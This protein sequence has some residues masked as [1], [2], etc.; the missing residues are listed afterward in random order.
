[1][2]QVGTEATLLNILEKCTQIEGYVD[3]IANGY[4]V[5]DWGGLK[6][7]VNN[8]TAEHEYPVGSQVLDTWAKNADTSYQ[9][10]WDVVDY[11]DEK[12]MYLKWHYGLPDNIQFDAPEAIYYA[13]S[14]GLAA[15]TY[16]IDIGSAYGDGWSTSK[17]IQ[18]TLQN[19]L[20]AGG[21]IYINCGTNYANDPT[22][23][24]TGY[25]YSSG[26]STTA[27]ETF[28]TSNGT[29]GT[30]LGTIGNE[31]TQ[32]PNGN[33]NA[34]SRVVYGSGRWSQSAIRQ[35]LNSTADAGAWW[36]AQNGWDRPPAQHTTLRGFL[37]GCP[38]DFVNILEEVEVV[39]ALNTVEGYTEASEITH[40]KIFLPSL[41][42][43]YINP[44][45]A[46]TE[47]EDWQYY[48][49]LA[50]EAGLDGKFQQYVTYPIL[51][52]YS[53]ANKTSAVYVWLRSA[54]R[55]Y[56]NNAWLVYSG[57]YV[58]SNYAYDSLSGCPACIIK[59]SQ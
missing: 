20:P 29:D 53:V 7:L 3:V 52:T 18:F 48:K 40:D 55:G 31:S 59:K 34:I 45:L 2:G 6:I 54:L 1:M 15:G 13:G 51:K 22:N 23:S 47:G 44:Q 8:L 37:A 30:S 21:Q 46:N 36:T 9:T 35:Y 43:M 32:K 41:Q 24:R 57:G 25:T 17:S 10:A 56:A 58:G 19:A 27:I 5:H 16:H 50:T 42:Q 26:N 4:D 14:E 12:N 28:T 39:T 49:D 33:L 38:S 11:D